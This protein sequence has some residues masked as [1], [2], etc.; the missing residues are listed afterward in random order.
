MASRETSRH[1]PQPLTLPRARKHVE[2][3]LHPD[4]M[5]RQGGDNTLQQGWEEQARN[6]VRWARQP[7]H[8]SYWRFHRDAFLSLVPSPGRLT[9]DI[10]CGEGRLARDLKAG[11]HRVMAIDASP[12]L[13]AHAREADP[14]MDV[15]LADAARLPLPDQTADLAVA[16]PLNSAGKFSS[17]APDA[18]FI[19]ADDYFARHTYSDAIERE[20]LPMTFHSQHRPLAGYFSALEQAGFLVEALR[21]VTVGQ[22]SLQDPRDPRWLRIPLFLHV[23]A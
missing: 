11:G 14:S 1:P 8:D 18:P 12:T 2:R 16:H 7:G 15:L 21:E 3:Y 20:G 6:W 13:V 4:K 9:L 10:G 23:R 22:G 17:D 5:T 19:I